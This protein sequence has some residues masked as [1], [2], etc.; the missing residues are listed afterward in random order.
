MDTKVLNAR[1]K[2]I[3]DAQ[4]R[5]LKSAVENKVALT[6]ADESAFANM[7]NELDQINANLARI[8]AIEKGRAEVNTPV[9]NALI[10]DPAQ[11]RQFVAF[12]GNNKTKLNVSNDYVNGFWQSLRSKS[13]FDRFMI[14]NAALCEGGSAAAGG[15]LVPVETS[16]TIAAMAIE[17]C[18]ARSLSRVIETGMNLQLPYQAA[19]TSASLKTESNSS[20]TNAFG[21]SSPGFN[22]T[23]LGAY[24]IG[25]YVPVSW[26]LLQDSRAASQFVPFD[27]KRGI[28]TREEA[29]FISG[30][31]TNQPQGYLGNGITASGTSITAGAATLGIDPILDLVSSIKQAYFGDAK[32]LVNRQEFNR[33]LKQQ[34]ALSQFQN[35]V[36]WDP[37]GAARL[38]GYPVAFSSEMPVY[39]ASPATEGAWLFGSFS[40]FATIGDRGNSDILVKVLDQPEA[41]NGQTLILGFRRADQRILIQEAVAQLNTNG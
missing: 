23:T 36:T 6:V 26:E 16:G 24:M 33:L 29:L 35:F 14:S 18:S 3:L 38:L 5:L 13:E 7:T 39:A 32:F 1:K 37:S 41:L 22:T 34:V 25:N 11:V 20:G 30:T 2:E 31:G 8:S 17:E 21:Q 12:G 28:T 9:Q 4:E 10:T 27:I 40:A 19:L 15:A